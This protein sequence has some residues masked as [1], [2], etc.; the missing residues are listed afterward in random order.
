MSVYMHLVQLLK[1]LMFGF[2]CWSLVACGNNGR[3]SGMY[4]AKGRKVEI[5]ENNGSYT[6]L[7]NGEPYFIKGAGGYHYFDKIKAAGGNS[8]RIWHSED[9]A[10]VLDEAHRHGLTVTLG[11]WMGRE[12]DG[13]NYYDK[14]L[15]AAQLKALKK[16]VQ[17]HKDHPAL[18]M[19]GIG[20]ELNLDASNTKVWGAVNEVAE[21]I[22]ELDPEHPTT[23][24]I[25]GAR[26]KLLSLIRRECPAIDL[27]SI[28]VFGYMANIPRKILESEWNGPYLISEYGARGYWESNTSWWYAPLEQTSSQK[29]DFTRERYE[30]VLLQPNGG[31]LG[32]YLFFWGNKY[33]ATPTW[34][35]LIA[36]GGEETETVNVMRELWKG[37]TT[38]NKAPRVLSI[39]LDRKQAEDNIY[40]VTGQEYEARIAIRD[41]EGDTLRVIWEVMPETVGEFG[42]TTDIAPPAVRGLFKEAGDNWLRLRA[43]KQKGAYRLFAYVYDGKGNVATANI[44]FYANSAGKWLSADSSY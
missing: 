32:G 26:A 40:L 19:W 2:V 5:V 39:S 33:E 4:V 9:A 15:V 28:N 14:D 16:V 31:C 29:A 41:P 3:R 8:V 22:K 34:Y 44:P 21:M 20:N 11:L 18:L 37:D 17:R 38:Y 27:I 23:T 6:L 24:M 12:A 1:Y 42:E 43:P 25:V 10:R 30:Q 36:P 7:R 13:F 35:S